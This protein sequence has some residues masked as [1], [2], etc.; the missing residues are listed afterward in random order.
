M[1]ELAYTINGEAFDLPATASAWRIRRMKPRGAPEVVYSRDGV[2]QTISVEAGLE[3]LRQVVGQPGKYRLDAIDDHGKT[4]EKLPAAYVI[5]PPREGDDQVANDNRANDSSPTGLMA[6]A[7][8]M[9]TELAKAVIDRFPQMVEAAATL[10]RAA[11][12]A[13][14]PARPP[15]AVDE[16]DEED[17]APPP[18]PPQGDIY[19][20]LGPVVQMFAASLF[21]GG[22]KMPGGLGAILDWRKATPQKQIA[23]KAVTERASSEAKTAPPAGA[24]AEAPSAT[25]T[26]SDVLPPLDP[27]TMRHFLAI[28]AALEPQEAMLAREVARE[29]GP[30]KLRAWF[31]ELSKL[32]VP[33]AVA[34]VRELLG[35]AQKGGAA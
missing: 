34:R 2:P 27:A 19:A 15:R 22:I 33:D 20:L 29:L 8:R 3:E 24:I 12:G 7:M 9:N 28:Q 30:A 31:D 13:G 23:D 35:A 32:S 14:L 16:D 26:Q 10:L 5:V 21:G 25:E 6:E 18:P 1:S 11:D 4:I 17:E